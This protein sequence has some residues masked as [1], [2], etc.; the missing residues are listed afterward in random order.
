MSGKALR[1]IRIFHELK[2]V[3]MATKLGISKSYLSEIER[4]KTS[5]LMIIQKYANEFGLPVSSIL[6]FAEGLEQG[7]S[8]DKARSMVAPRIMKLMKFL[9]SRRTKDDAD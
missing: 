9:E 5:T 3:K 6:F 4:D 1:L 7:T 8:F 2:Q